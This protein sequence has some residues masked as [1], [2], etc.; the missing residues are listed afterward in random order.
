VTEQERLEREIYVLGDIIKANATVLAS[1]MMS[2]MTR[3]RFSDRQMTRRM[4]TRKLS[5]DL[6]CLFAKR[7][8]C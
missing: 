8:N 7:S 1:K 6:A 3:N 4:V 5:S 2:K